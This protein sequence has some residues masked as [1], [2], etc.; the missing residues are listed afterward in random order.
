MRERLVRLPIGDYF[1]ERITNP[2]NSEG[3]DNPQGRLED[4]LMKKS[5]ID[6]HGI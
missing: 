3:R 6:K 5:L 2:K 4:L 1:R